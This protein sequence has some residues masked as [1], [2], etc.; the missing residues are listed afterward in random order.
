MQGQDESLN[1]NHAALRATGRLDDK[2]KTSVRHNQ[3][4]A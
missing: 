1:T 3:S 4:I 2:Y